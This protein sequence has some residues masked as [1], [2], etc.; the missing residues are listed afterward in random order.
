MARSWTESTATFLSEMSGKA[1]INT[2]KQPENIS[3]HIQSCTQIYQGVSWERDIWFLTLA[4]CG[5]TDGNVLRECGYDGVS[6]S[7]TCKQA[8]L[9]TGRE[10]YTM[11]WNAALMGPL[12]LHIMCSKWTLHLPPVWQNSKWP[13]QDFTLAKEGKPAS[14]RLCFFSCVL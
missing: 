1:N 14:L 9:M 8:S 5:Q 6:W 12:M 10:W 7:C 3:N 2:E 11:S 4:N 13:K